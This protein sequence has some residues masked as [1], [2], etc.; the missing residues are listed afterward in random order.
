M[1]VVRRH[2]FDMGLLINGQ[3]IPDPTVFTGAASALDSS[4]S[5]DA[6]GMLHRNMVATKHPLK[7]EYHAITFGTMSYIMGL[8]T[9]S[10]FQFTFPDPMVGV[11]TIDAYVGDRDWELKYAPAQE[12]PPGEQGPWMEQWLGDLKFSII[13]Y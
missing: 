7:L 2:N 12:Y 8:M 6:N 3:R 11:I 4:G 1:D 10:K 9:G 5:R 13:E